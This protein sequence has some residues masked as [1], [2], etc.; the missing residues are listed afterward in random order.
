MMEVPAAQ[1]LGKG[2]RTEMRGR[3]GER[4]WGGPHRAW[5]AVP[6]GARDVGMGL[7]P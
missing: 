3:G 7:L 2:R 1:A 5:P 6:C 4:R